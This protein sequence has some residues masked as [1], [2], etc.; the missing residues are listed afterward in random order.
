[1]DGDQF[2]STG[3]NLFHQQNVVEDENNFFM[4]SEIPMQ[5]VSQ[6]ESLKHLNDY[7]YNILREDAYKDVND[8]VFKL[9]YKI[10]KTEQEIAEVSKQI[11]TASEIRDNYLLETLQN[12]KLKLQENLKFITDMYNE[13][14]LS[15][16]ISGGI[17][18]KFREKFADVYRTIANVSRLLMSKL[19]GK[20]ASLIE[21]RN[22]L[23]KLEYI[24]RSV[25][26][27]MR[28]RY[29]YG[30]AVEKYEQLSKYIARANS[31]QSEIYKF[32][33]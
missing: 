32:I 18:S 2:I 14:S 12:R 23:T 26:D 5:N 29:P 11:Q 9:E 22:S 6:T 27:L 15:A 4:Q 28:S 3:S 33:K 31:I 8:E 19:P 20:L 10:S 17:T 25:D 1:M 7:D 16:K 13:A 30:E 24:N 21:V